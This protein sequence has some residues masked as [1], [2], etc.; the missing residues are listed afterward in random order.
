LARN[1]SILKLSWVDWTTNSNI[2]KRGLQKLNRVYPEFSTW[3][4]FF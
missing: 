4:L 3:I 2:G 1:L